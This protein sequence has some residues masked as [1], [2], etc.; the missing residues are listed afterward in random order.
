MSIIV[1]SRSFGV[2]SG[3]DIIVSAL[4]G[5]ALFKLIDGLAQI[6]ANLPKSGWRAVLKF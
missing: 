3:L 1:L 4:T 2:E 5:F 6:A